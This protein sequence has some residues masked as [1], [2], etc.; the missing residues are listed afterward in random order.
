[1]CFIE[2]IMESI[3]NSNRHDWITELKISIVEP[4]L[5]ATVTIN[6]MGNFENEWVLMNLFWE[7]WRN[8]FGTFLIKFTDL[9]FCFLC[10]R[11]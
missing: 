7:N 9:K 10:E 11:A 4:A 5:H 8:H 3:E 2:S 1:M 6:W